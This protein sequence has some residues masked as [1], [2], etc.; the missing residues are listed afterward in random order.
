[1]QCHFTIKASS[2]NSPIKL[3]RLYWE[4]YEFLQLILEKETKL[5]MWTEGARHTGTNNVEHYLAWQS[6][7]SLFVL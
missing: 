3:K 7:V 5:E 6:H 4:G 2:I 1:M